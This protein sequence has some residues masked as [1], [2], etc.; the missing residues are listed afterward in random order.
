METVQKHHRSYFHFRLDQL[1]LVNRT[2]HNSYI[3][4]LWADVI[5]SQSPLLWNLVSIQTKNQKYVSGYIDYFITP[6]GKQR[7]INHVSHICGVTSYGVHS[8]EV[9]AE[10]ENVVKMNYAVDWK[11]DFVGSGT[12]Y[13]DPLRI[14]EPLGVDRPLGFDKLASWILHYPTLQAIL[15]DNSR[16]YEHTAN[17]M[18]L[19][20]DF[21]DSQP[22]ITYV[23][24]ESSFVNTRYL[25]IFACALNTTIYRLVRRV[26][27]THSIRSVHIYRGR[28]F[29]LTRLQRVPTVEADD[30]AEGE[31]VQ[32]Q[33]F[34]WSGPSNI[35][36]TIL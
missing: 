34:Q 35:T 14:G 9:F 10:T 11:V 13:P 6:D 19:F 36:S 17:D 20:L 2:W 28:R 16:Y 12:P 5:T 3:P 15:I 4:I 24:L 31:F 32:D 1:H 18:A 8:L 25:S 23:Y 26:E 33:R 21:L 27:N 22:Q 29:P 7:L 30:H